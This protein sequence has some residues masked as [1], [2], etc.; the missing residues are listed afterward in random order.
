MP[1]RRTSHSRPLPPSPLIHFSS[2]FDTLPA[3]R[4][5]RLL[6]R[7]ANDLTVLKA[8]GDGNSAAALPEVPSLSLLTDN[9]AVRKAR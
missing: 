4:T 7:V 5:A 1:R 2:H 8:L 6:E 9:C 3:G